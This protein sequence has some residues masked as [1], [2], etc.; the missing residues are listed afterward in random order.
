MK[1]NTINF[2]KAIDMV[3]DNGGGIIKL[4]AGTYYF[5]QGG[6]A[7]N[8]IKERYAIKPRNNVHIIGAGTN[9]NNTNQLT[10]LKPYFKC[11]GT[12]SGTM[13]MFYFNN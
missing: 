12:G 8:S 3:S 1:K 10:I 5:F 11:D 2:Q 13:D 4:P 7:S 9:E 6:R